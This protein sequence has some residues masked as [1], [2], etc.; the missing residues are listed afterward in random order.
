MTSAQ[1][2]RSVTWD[3]T[4]VTVCGR[5][6]RVAVAG[7]GPPVFVLP[8]DQGHPPRSE[9]LDDLAGNARVYYPWLA[10][11]HGGNP[12]DWE[13]LTNVR[14]LAIVHRQM[15]DALDLERPA[16]V[17]LG[18]GGWVAA[19]IATM[20]APQ[21]RALVLVSPMGIKPENGYI[22]DQFLV[23][24]EHYAQT[25]Y[26]DQ[27]NF[28]EVYGSET[29]LEQLEAWETDRE[30][31]SRLAWRPYMYNPALPGLLSGVT[32]PALIAWGED[33][34]VVPVECAEAYRNALPNATVELVPN[35]G[36]AAEMEQPGMLLRAVASFLAS[37]Q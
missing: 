36:H 15:L 16:I 35:S 7:S 1:T 4:T 22:Y 31:V 17:G 32:T 28:R 12:D 27:T 3:E 34:Q 29:T 8:R 6:L 21:L 30:M 18:F 37:H 23:S 9:F 10:G 24:T 5:P 25:A 2:Q 13:W 20:A 19:E 14:D 26:H 33:D 11:F